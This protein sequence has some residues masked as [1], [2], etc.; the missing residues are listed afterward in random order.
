LISLQQPS[1]LPRHPPNAL[2]H[3][4]YTCTKAERLVPVRSYSLVSLPPPAGRDCLAAAMPIDNSRSDAS[5]LPPSS[6]NAEEVRDETSQARFLAILEAHSG[7]LQC[8]AAGSAWSP[9]QIFNIDFPYRC[10]VRGTCTCFLPFLTTCCRFH[11]FELP[12]ARMAHPHASSTKL[13]YPYL[14]LMGILGSDK[15]RYL[16]MG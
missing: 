16:L 9:D 5:S 6:L 13:L 3:A 4:I 10:L 7:V 11:R 1:L 2:V 14:S 15:I 12:D 8:P